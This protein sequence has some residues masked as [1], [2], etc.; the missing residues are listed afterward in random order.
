LLFDRRT[1]SNHSRIKTEDDDN[2]TS[3]METASR[4]ESLSKEGS[5]D[6]SNKDN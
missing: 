5:K 1:L 3:I 6:F 4:K 2:D